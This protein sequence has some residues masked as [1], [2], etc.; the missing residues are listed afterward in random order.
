MLEYFFVLAIMILL[1]TTFIIVR[2]GV[3]G[4]AGL[5]TKTNASLCMI[6]AAAFG[7]IVSGFQ[8]A[9][10]MILLGLVFGLVGD[11]MLDLK[12]VD[13]R[14]DSY[15]TN[16]GMAAFSLGHL[17]YFVAIV[18]LAGTTKL[19]VPILVAAGIAIAFA[20]VIMFVISKPMKLDF[21]KYFWQSY[22]Y[23]AILVFMTSFSIFIA[24]VVPNMWIFAVG[25][26][27]FLI[28]DLILSTQ[29]FGGKLHDKMLI[30]LNHA[31]YYIAQILIFTVIYFI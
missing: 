3:G 21:G 14:Y 12:V 2:C 26:G 4:P 22:A 8:L 18:L 28:S 27:F 17:C 20:S 31:T 10:I 5:V 30:A 23:C 15:Y 13:T 24:A 25:L 6:I 9:F 19:L 11:I 1:V 16:T 7:I 29:Y